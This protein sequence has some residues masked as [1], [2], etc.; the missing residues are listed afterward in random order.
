MGNQELILPIGI[1]VGMIAMII[2][3]SIAIKRIERKINLE[4]NMKK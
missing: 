2:I 3:V 1:L 4:T